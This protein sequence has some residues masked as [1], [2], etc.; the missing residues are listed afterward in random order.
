MRL[1]TGTVMST[2]VASCT[3][4]WKEPKGPATEFELSTGEYGAS[5]CEMSPTRVMAEQLA[6]LRERRKHDEM[7]GP[8]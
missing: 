7:G 1:S 2:G 4:R 6:D 3:S 5:R 8:A